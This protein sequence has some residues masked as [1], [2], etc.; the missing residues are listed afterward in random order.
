MDHLLAQSHN[1]LKSAQPRVT[2]RGQLDVNILW[3]WYIL[4]DAPS[5]V[6]L[7]GRAR[8]NEPSQVRERLREGYDMFTFVEKEYPTLIE[9]WKRQ[10]KRGR[11]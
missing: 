11:Q 4:K 3:F 8:I 2:S 1:A 6:K 5:E 7:L 10:R 9:K